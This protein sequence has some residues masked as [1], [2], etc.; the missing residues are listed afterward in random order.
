MGESM[1]FW[2]AFGSIMLIPSAGHAVNPARFDLAC[3]VTKSLTSA[4]GRTT[5]GSVKETERLSIDL[6]N[7]LWCSRDANTDCGIT[8]PLI[9]D[10]TQI[11]LN[12]GL[13]LDRR[14]GL[15]SMTGQI[16]PVT[17]MREYRCIKRPFTP[18]PKVRF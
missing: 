3:T 2:T 7:K 11:R 5:M 4:N 17:S 1:R 16:G 12:D 13:V 18:L 14:S 15:L 9:L 6:T 8:K 10:P